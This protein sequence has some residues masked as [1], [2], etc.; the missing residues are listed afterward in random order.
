[1]KSR[2]TKLLIP[3]VTILVVIGAIAVYQLT[4]SQGFAPDAAQAAMNGASDTLSQT[5][6]KPAP[7]FALQDVDGTVHHL[8]DY[9]GKVV[10]LNFWAT[11]CPPCR[12]EIPEFA[13][14]QK[15]YGDQGI[16]FL[17]IAMDDEG[18]AK[19]KPW[20]STHPVSY[21]ILLPNDKVTGSYG[22]MSSIPV[23]FVIDRKG[24]I[25]SSFVGYRVDTLVE[26]MFKP[27]LAEK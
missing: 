16:Q 1:M 20:L 7:D 21:P 10:M 9:R 5:T 13:D 11:W 22:E 27:L 6:P 17:G 15:K 4:S 18:L 24:M 2:N 23:T 3:V 25:R 19:V 8:S 26:A 14:L 12:K